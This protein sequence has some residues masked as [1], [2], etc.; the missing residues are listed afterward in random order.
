MSTDYGFKVDGWG[1]NWN[2]QNHSSAQAR[3]GGRLSKLKVLLEALKEGNVVNAQ[4]AILDLWSFDLSLKADPYL[5]KINEELSKRQI[6]FAQKTAILMQ[7]DSSHFSSALFP[8]LP[9]AVRS[10]EGASR[11][12]EVSPVAASAASKKATSGE[13]GRLIDVSA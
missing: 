12:N 2:G 7:A 6:Y 8:R 11:S 1:S 3:R 4:K 5:I 9:M 10:L 13:F